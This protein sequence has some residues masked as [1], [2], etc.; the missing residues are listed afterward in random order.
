[1][2]LISFLNLVGEG[3]SPPV[4][5]LLRPNTQVVLLLFMYWFEHFRIFISAGRLLW[6][7]ILAAKYLFSHLSRKFLS[8]N[9][10]SAT[11]GVV[12]I[13]FSVLRRWSFNLITD[14]LYHAE[15][16]G[17]VKS[18]LLHETWLRSGQDDLNGDSNTSK[19][20]RVRSKNRETTSTD[21]GFAGEDLGFRV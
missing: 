4:L 21:Y 13:L 14:R 9:F 16:R 19:C 11:E 10:L 8:M 7:M 12:L 18:V 20:A 3:I 2:D 17:G 5:P 15:G 1:M 6:N